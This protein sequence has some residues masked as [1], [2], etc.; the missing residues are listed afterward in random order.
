M[1][2][3]ERN[4]TSVIYYS[5][6]VFVLFFSSNLNAQTEN[7]QIERGDVLDIVVMEHPEFSIS[8]ILVLPDGNVQFPALG[9]VK[10]AGKS[11]I[12]LSDTLQSKLV[13]YVVDPIVTV[14]VRQINN[15]YVNILG[16]VNKPGQYQIFE[17]IKVMSAISLAGGFS[18]VQKLKSI[19]IIRVNG[20]R[21]KLKVAEFME[22]PDI[23]AVLKPGDTIYIEPKKEFNWSKLTF[24]T[25]ILTVVVSILRLTN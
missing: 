8:N 9:F 17:P 21:E 10:A 25:S 6:F 19:S 16:G 22:T 14:Y 13:K 24:V 12:V 5:F 23:F 7:Y 15:Q 20:E 18:D 1:L 4:I 2:K 3:L 11:P